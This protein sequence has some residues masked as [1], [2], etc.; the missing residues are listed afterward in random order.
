MKS[1]LIFL[2][3]CLASCEDVKKSIANCR[4][5]QPACEEGYR[6]VTQLTPDGSKFDCVGTDTQTPPPVSVYHPPAGGEEYLAGSD[7]VN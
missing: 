4:L 2:A 5:N 1:V 7:T 3:C 6:C